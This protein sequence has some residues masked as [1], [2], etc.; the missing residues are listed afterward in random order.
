MA[1][2]L[3]NFQ[4]SLDNCARFAQTLFKT[5]S[6]SYIFIMG[7]YMFFCEIFLKLQGGAYKLHVSLAPFMQR[8][9][10]CFFFSMQKEKFRHV[11][12]PQGRGMCGHSLPADW[13][14]WTFQCITELLMF[15]N[16]F[17]QRFVQ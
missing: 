12:W 4:E 2:E 16:I 5:G 13:S 17:V 3:E 9:S 10:A 8:P 7:C 15:I 14:F 11:L 6:K 1:G